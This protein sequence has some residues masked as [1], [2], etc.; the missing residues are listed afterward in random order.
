M[1]TATSSKSHKI[2]RIIHGRIYDSYSE[3]WAGPVLTLVVSR[4]TQGFWS[5][6]SYCQI[7]WRNCP[8]LEK[9]ENRKTSTPNKI[10]EIDTK[11]N[12]T[13]A[14]SPEPEAADKVVE[15][16]KAHFS[17]VWYL[18]IGVGACAVATP[19][20]QMPKS[21][22]LSWSLCL[23][24][25]LLFPF[26]RMFSQVTSTWSTSSLLQVFLEEVPSRLFLTNLF[27]MTSQSLH[28]FELSTP[29]LLCISPWPLSPSD[30]AYV[31]YLFSQ[32]FSSH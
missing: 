24:L 19:L 23:S 1:N 15:L 3:N 4:Q 7:H 25:H 8:F 31:W 5:N 20:I 22:G 27:R 10:L 29:F 6:S 17:A 26:P 14:C 21:W 9:K 18:E 12:V 16:L 2:I 30:V 28:P 32:I 11:W 13:T